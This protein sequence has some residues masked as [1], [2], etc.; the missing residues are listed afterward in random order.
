MLK[1][2][3]KKKSVFALVSPVKKIRIQ[4]KGM[5]MKRGYGKIVFIPLF[6]FIQILEKK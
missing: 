1:K 2:I 5:K 3:K 4:H 6:C